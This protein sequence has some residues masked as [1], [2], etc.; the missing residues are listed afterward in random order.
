MILSREVKATVGRVPER[1]DHPIGNLR[2]R[3]KPFV[4]ECKFIE[5]KKAVRQ[6][7][8][9]VQISVNTRASVF[10]R[11][12]QSGAIPHRRQDEIRI[13]F[14]SATIVISIKMALSLSER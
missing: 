8:V 13:R 6:I 7:R 12:Q 5:R 10:K 3:V 2:R 11:V 14:G 4:V 9:I 1:L